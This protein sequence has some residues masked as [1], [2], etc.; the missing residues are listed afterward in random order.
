MLVG[1]P[2]P[3]TVVLQKLLSMYKPLQNMRAEFGPLISICGMY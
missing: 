3:I 1:V 2:L